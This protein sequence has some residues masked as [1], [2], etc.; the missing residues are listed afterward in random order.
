M[1][2]YLADARRR[3]RRRRV[4][5]LA[6]P[7]GRCG[8]VFNPL[9]VHWCY[10][11]DGALACIVAEVHNTYGERH[12]Y[13]LRPDERGR[14]EADKEFYVSPFF[15][16]RRP[17]P[18]AVLGAGRAA[19]ITMALRQDGATPFTASVRGTARPATVRTVL[20]AALRFPM[21]SLRVSALIRLQ[22]VKL[23][24]RRLPVVPRPAAFDRRE[25]VVTTVRASAPPPTQD[26]RFP[27]PRP[28]EAH[29]PGLATPPR[30]P[31]HARIAEAIFRRA[32]APLPG[33]G[34]LPRR[35]R[36]RRRRQGRPG[37]APGPAATPSSPGWAP[38]RRSAS[39]RPT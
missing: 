19:A 24:L 25:P 32:V 31:V 10:R 5:M 4:L 1:V 21:M 15:D 14:A 7:R 11:A 12:A 34:R 36:A 38:T 30:A 13:L 17:L 6:T 27:V 3:R 8:Y 33:A 16:G 9:S 20:R 28:D 39:A 29:W 26:A 37:D 22:G 2:A 35:P 23:W 18:D